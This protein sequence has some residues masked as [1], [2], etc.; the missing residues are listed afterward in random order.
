MHPIIAKAIADERIA[1]LRQAAAASRQA[2]AAASGRQDGRRPLV[3]RAPGRAAGPP[4]PGQAQVQPAGSQPAGRGRAGGQP[5]V[6]P[7]ASQ[8]T[9]SHS[10]AGRPG[11]STAPRPMQ[12][13]WTPE[14]RR[15]A[16][17]GRRPAALPRGRRLRLSEPAPGGVRPGAA[18]PAQEEPV[19]AS[20]KSD[21]NH[22]C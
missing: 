5:Q 14:Q 17:T 16:I 13:A 4:A 21:S 19:M 22:A 2:R 10:P 6:Q 3:H 15:A 12:A 9:D 20:S 7:A 1:D 8:R 11:T 18:G